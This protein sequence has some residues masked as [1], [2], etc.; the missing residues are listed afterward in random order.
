[1]MRTARLLTAY[2]SIQKEGAAYRGG[3]FVGVFCLMTL[4][5]G[6]RPIEQTDACENI[7][8][9]QLC[10]REVKMPFL[11]VTDSC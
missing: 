1:M 5:E 11:H 3:L 10:L 2:R 4:W 9:P 7:T 8:F 6:R